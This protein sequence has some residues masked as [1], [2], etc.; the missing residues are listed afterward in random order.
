MLRKN[1]TVICRKSSGLE[2]QIIN[3]VAIKAAPDKCYLHSKNLSVDP[4]MIVCGVLTACE[5]IKYKA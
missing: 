3:V 5:P 1:I 2:K 4:S